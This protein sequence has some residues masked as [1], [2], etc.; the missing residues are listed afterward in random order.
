MC[1]FSGIFRWDSKPVD[2]GLLRRMTHT[3]THRGPDDAGFYRS[4]DDNP[5]S[6]G[7]VGLGFRRLSIIDLQGGH[8]PMTTQEKKNWIVFNGEIY[9]F[10]DLRKDLEKRGHRFLTRSDTEVI[11]HLY[12]R[13]GV[14]CVQHLRGMFAFAIWDSE[15]QSL[16]LARDR[17]GKKPLFY[18][19]KGNAFYF[20]SEMKALLEAEEIQKKVRMESVPLYFAYQFIPSPLTIFEE[21]HRLPPAHTLVCD[22][23]GNVRTERY[24]QISHAPRSPKSVPDLCEEIRFRLNESTKIRLISDVPLGAFL[25]GGIDSSAVVGLMAQQM[26][27]PVKTFSIGFEESDFS[28]LDYARLVAKRFGTDHHEFVVKPETADTLPKLAWF[29][30][31]PFADPSALP[32]YYVARETRKHVT[33]ALNGDG[34][35]ENFGGYLRYRAD[36]IFSAFS[37]IPLPF[38]QSLQNAVEKMPSPLMRSV[39]MRRLY[40]AGRVLGSST[41][42]FNY[43]VFCYFDEKAQ[44]DLFQGDLLQSSLANKTYGYFESLYQQTDSKEFLD[45]VL[46]CD[47]QGYL[48]DCLLVKMDIATMANSLEARSPFLDHT[49]I[50]LAAK[51]PWEY[52]VKWNDGKWILKKALKELL[53]PEIV[54]RQ[55]MGFGLPIAHWFRGALKNFLRDAL[56]SPSARRRGYFKMEKVEQLIQEHQSHARDHSYKLWAL[57]MFELWHT[58]Y[59]DP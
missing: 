46:S 40:R 47:L 31:Q 52:K 41:R 23:Q 59:L 56:L 16:F 6:K 36:R 58:V 8:Q 12:D 2:P 44:N 13:Y 19:K 10:L 15:K 29:Y 27:E 22:S 38:R 33:V 35:D 32:S 54:Q 25:S 4:E 43:K 53:P 51:I 14:S 37:K 7:R 21:I 11:L 48:P 28:E 57:L 39:F 5:T 55:K 42:E 3:L 9:N 26:S 24:W 20:A 18:A 17:I 50:E 34:G 30:D 1:G 45:Q 49:L